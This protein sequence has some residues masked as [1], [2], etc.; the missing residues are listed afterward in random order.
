MTSYINCEQIGRIGQLPSEDILENKLSD[1][2]R[3]SS[4]VTEAGLIIDPP[5]VRSKTPTISY[6]GFRATADGREYALRVT[7]GVTPRF[8]VLLITHEAFAS[9][10]ARYQDAPDLC[11][12]KLSRDLEADPDLVPVP[13]VEVTVRELREYGA[14]RERPSP[15]PK[16]R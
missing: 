5:V 8:F 3:S 14:A 7:D 15:G 6:L 2:A 1:L 4:R 12:S 16:R 13:R 10:E 9:H 11:F